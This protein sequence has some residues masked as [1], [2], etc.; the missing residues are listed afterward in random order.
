MAKGKKKVENQKAYYDNEADA[1][2]AMSY[3]NAAAGIL[4]LIIWALYL[5]RIFTIPEQFFPTVCVLFPVAAA[6]MFVPLFFLKT[7][8]LRK[9][10]YKYF[11]LFSLMAVIIA[12]NIFLP[13]HSLLFWPFAILIANHYYNPTVGVVTYLV[14]VV[15]MLV[16]LYLGMFFGEFDENLFG[17]GVIKPDGTIGTV[18]TLQERLDLLQTRIEQGDNRYIK[19]LIYYYFPRMA[20]VTLFF[21]VSDLLN[22]RTYKLLDNEIQIHD[23]QEKAKTEL[24]VA[25]GIQLNTLPSE[26]LASDDVEIVGELKAAKEVGGDLYDYVEIDADHVAVLVGDVSGKG[27]PA[28][29]F[30]M[31]T[32]TS[33]RDFAVA[34]KSPSE[35][36]KA[37]NA[38]I[39]KG[40]KDGM[41]VTCFLAIL[42]KRSGKV[43][44]ANAGHNPPIVGSDF[45]YQYLKSNPGLLLGCF[46]STF[47]KDEEFVLKPGETMTLYTDGITEARNNE[48]DFFGEERFLETMNR[49]AH[50]CII[51]LHHTIKDAIYAFV[52]GAP[53]SDD[54]TLV[55]LKFRGDQYLAEEKEFSAKKEN[56]LEMLGFINDFCDKC[57]FAENFKNKLTIVGDELLSNIIRHG[58]EDNGGYI[59]LR[60]LFD[61]DTKEFVMTLIDKAKPFNQLEVNNNPLAGDGQPLQIGGLGLIIVKNIM[62]ECAYDR[63]NGKN[64]LVLKKRF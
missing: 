35:I 3:V 7:D 64:I 41:F 25:R 20:I 27:V 13:K 40:N 15:M 11:I 26:V 50:T 38:S 34:G 37:I 36:L 18:E 16:C 23:E 63:I 8:A 10:G 9:P 55:T 53:Q 48:G 62:T 43:T 6:L 52:N 31:K 28:A 32:I 58:Y 5:A 17:G 24:N 14:S 42:D 47:V 2:K 61:E 51:E 30:M 4:A 21:M 12:L 57:Q 33:F 22:K 39:F 19:V 60:L 46:N 54:I 44:Y 1:N 49:Q 59:Y 29:M 56:V 45:R